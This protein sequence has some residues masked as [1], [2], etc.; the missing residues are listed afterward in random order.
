MKTDMKMV[1]FTDE[2]RATLE[3][4]DNA[5]SH[6]ANATQAFLSSIGYSEAVNLQEWDAVKL[7]GRLVERNQDCCK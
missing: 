6:S 4:H 3:G 7:E 1:L 5:P 2:T